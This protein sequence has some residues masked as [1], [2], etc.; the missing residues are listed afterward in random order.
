[1]IYIYRFFS[2]LLYP[3][4][5]VLIFFRKFLNKEDKIRFKEKIFSSTFLK[6]FED[7]EKLIWFHAASIGEVQSIIPIIEKLNSNKI[8]YN[9]LITTTTFSS[10]K[11]FEEK[12]KKYSNITHRYLPL[13]VNFLVR[14]F[15]SIWKP[16]AVILVDSEIWP[17]LILNLREKKIPI[18]IINGR[19]TYRT[20]K[21]WMAIRNTSLKIFGIF[22]LILASNLKSKEYFEKLGGKDIFYFGN[23]KFAQK[24]DIKKIVNINEDILKTRN[25]WCAVSTHNNEEK[26]CIET[27]IE[28]K[29]NLKMF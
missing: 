18:S 14:K 22:D 2:T 26:Y 1:M 3:I 20:F 28:I 7:Q 27:H 9:F 19:L 4:L 21:R 16:Y 25:Y 5:I 13:D 29:K 11:F 17:N 12:L 23:I 24:L 10:G 15:I 6:S 8:K